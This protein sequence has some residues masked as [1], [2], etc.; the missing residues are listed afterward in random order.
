MALAIPGKTALQKRGI[1][2]C[3]FEYSIVARNNRIYTKSM[4][5][6]FQPTVACVMRIAP[7]LGIRMTIPRYHSGLQDRGK[8]CIE[9]FGPE[10]RRCI[11]SIV[12]ISY[13]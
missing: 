6:E 12:Q 13:W 3:I 5:Q 4:A 10:L 8:P 1:P 7:S 11:R 2:D 9:N